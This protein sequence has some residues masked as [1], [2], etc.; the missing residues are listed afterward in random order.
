MRRIF[1]LALGLGITF[2]P[3]A[4]KIAIAQSASGVPHD[5]VTKSLVYDVISVKPTDP[6][7]HA[8][9]HRIT[10]DGLSMNVTLKSLIFIAYSIQTDSQ[11]SGLPAWAA[12][13]QFDV[14]AKMDADTA[15]S[16]AKLPE[17]EQIKQRQVMLQTLLADRFGLKV[18]HETKELRVYKLVVAKGGLKMK[19]T[20]ADA[21]TG[22][23]MGRGQYTGRG[24]TIGSLVTYLSGTLAQPVVD[25]TGLT[26]NYNLRLRYKPDDATGASQASGNSQD[27]GPSL[28]SALQEQLGLK[29][30]PARE[31]MDTI[32]VDHLERPS[33]N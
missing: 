18:H 7:A 4:S 17:D 29:L 32:I 22:V 21:S 20:P 6:D 16:L 27:F 33:E 31:P 3:L 15:A 5:A 25:R 19:H 8:W 2:F 24:I 14:E 26:G 1:T 13:A 23:R 9:W 10:A 28:F 12:T 30:D 11:I